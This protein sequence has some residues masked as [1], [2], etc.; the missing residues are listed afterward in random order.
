MAK[1]EPTEAFVARDYNKRGTWYM[2][3]IHPLNGADVNTV[4]RLGDSEEARR[5]LE[6]IRAACTTGLERIDIYDGRLR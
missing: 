5:A 1:A 2:E 4:V 6:S 3:V